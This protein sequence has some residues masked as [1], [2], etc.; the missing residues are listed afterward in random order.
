M[1]TN[2]TPFQALYG[3]QPPGLLRM[4]HAKTLVDSLNQL[5]RECDAILDD[6]WVSDEHFNVGD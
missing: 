5:L 6:L 1:S 2:M 4:G 3:R